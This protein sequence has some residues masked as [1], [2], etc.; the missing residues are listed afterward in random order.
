MGILRFLL[1]SL[2]LYLGGCAVI[3]TVPVDDFILADTAI[4]FAK[5][6]KAPRYAPG[7]WHR[8]E[9]AYRLGKRYY[10]KG[11][12]EKAR[13]F[14]LKARVYGEKSENAARL[15]RYKNGENF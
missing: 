15:L 10:K 12:Y 9:D 8:A 7:Q 11:N 5:L 4:K 14:F 6:A 1:F 3:V 2:G 13:E